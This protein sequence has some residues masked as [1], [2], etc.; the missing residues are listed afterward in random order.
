MGRRKKIILG[1]AS[2]FGLGFLPFCPGT[3]GSLAGVLIFWLISNQAVFLFIALSL[4]GL[5]FFISPAAEKALGQKD[6][7]K[8]VI[9]E[10]AGMMVAFI[11]I[12]RQPFFILTGFV[13]FRFLD[14]VKVFPAN[15]IDKKGGRFRVTGDDL[16]AGAYTNIALQL[17]RLLLKIS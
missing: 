12:P 5:A 16:V 6:S 9:D 13:I 10:L 4:T 2:V 8:I 1:L 17:L 7:Q 3:A 11:F 15:R 14:I